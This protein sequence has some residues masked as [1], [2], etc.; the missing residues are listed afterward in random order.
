MNPL[1]QLL[2]QLRLINKRLLVAEQHLL[3]A[4]R[5]DVIMKNAFI[6]HRRIL[7]GENHLSGIDLIEASDGTAGLQRLPRR[8]A[9]RV[10]FAPCWRP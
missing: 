1:R 3:I 8:V 6:D 5:D 10:A 9:L 2:Q 7:P 4:H